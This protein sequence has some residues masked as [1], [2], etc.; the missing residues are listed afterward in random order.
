M[1]SG[2]M[3]RDKDSNQNN[4][5][6]QDG[7]NPEDLIKLLKSFYQPEQNEMQNFDDFFGSIE[8]K[9]NEQNPVNQIIATNS[10][11]EKEYQQRQIKLEESINRLESNAKFISKSP[12]KKSINFKTLVL[13]ALL[14]AFIG[15]GL[16]FFN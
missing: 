1:D 8:K 11:L 9:L 2:L 4:K 5:G 15:L 13:G 10:E 3:V 6:G 12:E 7:S 16:M 14:L